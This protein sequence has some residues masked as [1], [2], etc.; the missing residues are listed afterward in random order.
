MVRKSLLVVML[1]AIAAPVAA[2]KAVQTEWT[3]RRPDG[4]A[5]LG[6][7]NGELLNKGE[8]R[9]SYTFTQ[10]DYKGLW[11]N[12]DSIPLDQA[13]DFYAQAPLTLRSQT[14][15][16]GVA[17]APRSDLTITARI[18]YTQREREQLTSDGVFFYVTD[19]KE[20][21]DLQ[22]SA[23]YSAF[24]QGNYRAHVQLGASVPTG[25][26]EAKDETPF[27][28]PGKQAL[29]YDMRAGSGT[30]AVLPGLT[31]L[32][33]NDLA[34]VG[35]QVRATIYV[36][37]NGAKFSPGDVYDYNAWAAY[38][39]NDYFS[40]SGRV[41]YQRW[42]AIK[43]ADPALDPTFDPGNDAYWLKG[44]RMDI[45]VGLNIYLPQGMHLGGNRLSVE[46]IYPV[47]QNYD[48][49]Q[50]GADWGLSIGWQAI[51]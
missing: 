45:P 41:H 10:M 47:S 11:A 29:S 51:F 3:S 12:G 48:G 14:H 13:F 22:V 39:I 18:P 23:L 27:S 36:G 32:A 7:V 2:Q 49:L 21:G 26:Y 15:E 16:V 31:M 25:K 44:R 8:V 1:L 9:F 6:V 50:L 38:K 30:V 20:L 28:S 4:Q 17:F 40:V 34:S 33:Q 46:Y 43:G 35:A 42:G 37:K 19:S 5:P 24:N